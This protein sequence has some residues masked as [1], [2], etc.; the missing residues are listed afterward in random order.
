MPKDLYNIL[1]LFTFIEQDDQFEMGL[2]LFWMT[3][4][5]P[6]VGMNG[7]ISIII[8]SLA[9]ICIFGFLRRGHR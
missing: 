9:D 6:D 1:D 5:V 4:S 2:F 8:S 3:K 7:Y